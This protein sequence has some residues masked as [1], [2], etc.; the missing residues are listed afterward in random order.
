MTDTS[1]INMTELKVGYILTH[2][3]GFKSKIKEIKYVYGD[4][5]PY[6]IRSVL[7]D[8]LFGTGLDADYKRDGRYINKNNPSDNDIVGFEFDVPNQFREYGFGEF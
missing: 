7:V 2:R 5:Y 4:V 1:R 6:K 3:G 8:S